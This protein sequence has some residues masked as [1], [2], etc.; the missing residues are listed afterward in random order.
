MRSNRVRG[1]S[2]VG[3]KRRSK[4]LVGSIVPTIRSI[5]TIA[6]APAP[7]PLM[8]SYSSRRTPGPALPAMV[9]TSPST[10][11]R[12]RL[13]GWPRSHPASLARLARR[14][15]RSKSSRASWRANP[16]RMVKTLAPAD[17]TS[18]AAGK[19]KGPQAGR[20]RTSRIQRQIRAD[21]ARPQRQPR[22][23]TVR[24]SEADASSGHQRADSKSDSNAATHRA[25]AASRQTSLFKLSSAW[26]R[27]GRRAPGVPGQS[28]SRRA[29][30]GAR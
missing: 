12:L 25:S 1:A 21:P 3:R 10:G 26:W 15:A 6:S 11:R 29:G 5:G 2:E 30:A 4:H 22:Q 17:Q 27:S 20:R 7:R 19:S 28:R 16:V 24:A 8:R 23:L 9:L 18:T 13:A 14:R